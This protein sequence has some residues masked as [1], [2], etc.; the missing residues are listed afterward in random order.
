M[1]VK[2]CK[3]TLGKYDEPVIMG[4]DAQQRGLAIGIVSA[5][6]GKFI[7]AAWVPFPKGAYHEEVIT[8][9]NEQARI[10]A[11]KV[12]PLI[13][14]V[15]EPTA[16]MSPTTRTLWGIYGAVVSGIFPYSNH[17][18]SIV[19]SAWKSKSGLFQW[20]KDR[21]ILTKGN[22]P[23]VNIKD[24]IIDIMNLGETFSPAD[25][26]DAIGIAYA[27]YVRNTERISTVE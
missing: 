17:C 8:I 1:K 27:S 16:R 10:V 21:G 15:E 12:H 26:Y 3:S 25:I 11:K 14:T 18:E 24:G 4:I 13:S 22:I 6:T 7:D 9:A 23:K 2:I 20:A 5:S 19:V